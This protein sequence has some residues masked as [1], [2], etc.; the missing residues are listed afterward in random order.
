MVVSWDFGDGSPLLNTGILNPVTYT[1]SPPQK[2]YIVTVV[3][4]DTLTNQID[5][6]KKRVI[7][8]DEKANFT[9]DKTDICTNGLV[10]FYPF[11]NDS[12]KI[13]TYTWDF[14]DSTGR[15]IIDNLANFNNYGLWLKGN[16]SH[17]Y[18]DTGLY[19][20]KFIIEDKLGC[21][22]SIYY[23]LPISVRGPLVNFIPDIQL[24]CLVPLKVIFTDSSV[25]NG[26]ISII[27]WQWTFGN[28]SP[29]LNSTLDTAVSNLYTVNTY[30][31]NLK[32]TDSIGCFS[33][34]TKQIV[35]PLIT[36]G[37]QA[38]FTATPVKS[39]TSP[40]NVVFTDT[41]IQSGSVPIVKWDWNFGNG[42]T[43]ITDTD[44]AIN[45]IYNGTYYYNFYTVSLTITDSFGCISSVSKPN[46]IKIYQPKADFFSY[47]TLKCGAFNVF[48][49]NY[50]QVYNGN[51]TWYY[52][53]AASSTGYYGSH[54]YA[55]EGNYNIKMVVQ[56]ENGCSDSI[57][58]T[59]YIKLV[60]PQANFR[61][62]DT[63]RCA[64][65]AIAFSDSSTY[66]SSWV[67]DFG[68]GGTGST[69]QYP[70][71]HIYALPGFY[72]VTLR[73]KGLNN[74]EDSISK[75]IRV[76]GPIATLTANTGNGCKP[77]STAMN[78]RGSFI[79]TYAWDYGDGTP[80]LPN[81]TDSN[82]AHTYIN[83]GRYLPNVI[84][85][86]PEGCPFT[87]KASD[88]VFVDSVKAKFSFGPNK[89]CDSGYV[90]FTDQSIVPFFSSIRYKWYFGDGKIDTTATPSSHLYN[91][92]GVY[93]VKL[94]VTS[95]YGCVDSF[96]VANAINIYASP[97]ATINGINTVCLQPLTKLQYSSTVTSADAITK[98]KWSIDADSVAN[99]P[100]LNYN[101]RVP[102]NHVITFFIQTVNG[103]TFTITKNILIDSI[104][105]N[106][107]INPVRFC[108]SG[109]ASFNNLTTNFGAINFYNWR[110]GDG[111]TSTTQNPSNNYL[112]PN[113]YTVRLIAATVN[114]CRDTTTFV[115]T[116]RVFNLPSATI[117]GNAIVCL[118]PSTRLQY[119]SNITSVD[120]IAKYKW[121]IDADSVANTPDLNY[122]YRT[123]GNHLITFFIQTVN[124]CIFSI[125]KNILI[126]SIVTDFSISQVRFCTFGSPNFNNLTTSYGAINF[127]NWSFGDGNTSAL[128]NPSNNYLLPNNYTVQLIAETINGCRDTTVFTDT[129]HIYNL[130]HAAIIGDSIHCTPGIYQYLSSINSVD[131][132]VKYQWF[133]DNVQRSSNASLNY[134]FIAGNHIVSLKVTTVNGCTDSVATNIIV[135]SVKAL[136]SISQNKFCADTA[137]VLFT[138]NTNHLF[139]IATYQWSFGDNSNA[140]LQS[141][142]HN[143]QQ[144]GIYDVKLIV[145]TEHGCTDTL[146]KP[147]AIE[148]YRNPVATFTG[149]SIHCTPGN[150]RYISGSTANDPIAQYQWKVNGNIAG[151]ADTLDHNFIPAGLYD[152]MLKVTTDKGCVDDTTRRIIIDSVGAKFS[153]ENPKICGDTGTVRFN[154]LSASRFSNMNYRWNFGDAQTSTDINLTHFYTVA[155]HYLAT[156]KATTVNGCSSTYQSTDTVIIYT[157]T[158]AAIVG[159]NEKCMQN[160]LVYQANIVTQDAITTY[161]WKLNN[162]TISNADTML[163]NFVNA[164]NYTVQLN[165][166]TGYGC[167]VTVSKPVV[168]HPLP[169]PA[170]A[171]D[172]TICRG[173]FVQLRSFDGVI[174]QWAASASLQNINSATPRAIPVVTTN[175][176]VAVTNQFGCVQNDTVTVVVDEPVN[177]TVSVNDSLCIGERRQLKATST[178]NNYLW[179]PSGTLSN[180]AAANPYASPTVTTPYQVIAFSNNVCNSD[181][182]Y[183]T[184]FVGNKP[185]VNAGADRN[186]A[187]GTPIQ[188]FAQAVGND[189]NRYLWEPSTGLDCVSCPNP[190]L[191][192]DDNIT[193]RVTVETIFG[194]TATDEMRI[195]VFCGKGQLY[196][197]NAFSPNGD[198]L[199]DIFYVKGFGLAKIKKMMIFNRLGQKVFE[200]QDV[201]VNDKSQGWNGETQG[202]PPTTTAAYVYILE[203]VCKDGQEFSYKGMLML[204]R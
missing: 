47:D 197:P 38:G 82:V 107:S 110:F 21:S 190:K 1:F 155:G 108:G 188:L 58:R 80:V 55:A 73:V 30:N 156:L 158:T 139:N 94:V 159:V 25:Q 8:I 135:D 90:N 153:I 182:G 91:V 89:F 59:S 116:I 204:V 183:V 41:S 115:D 65:T 92:P 144:A 132:I 128:Q 11:G 111:N 136:F 126:D 50:A 176:S 194:C 140:S 16:T 32:V 180:P 161:T 35:V 191:M 170:A 192:A 96:T 142:V 178:V 57:T 163:Y 113:N 23:P 72:K 76:R 177:L 40:Q 167:D 181:T 36:S 46:Y 184:I 56:D 13:K 63:T 48:L 29:V 131:N 186:V 18:I 201:P 54:T 162:N 42:T 78:V 86:S 101:Y 105:T 33:S 164:G 62:G 150:F 127:Y 24:S 130:P 87:L 160:V 133:V 27:N 81:I 145:T 93:T 109:M 45:K 199:N 166:R 37:P 125:T 124:G 67:W 2:A 106:F 66:S 202:Q 61:I 154:N 26:I 74:C 123:P 14:G 187:N 53:D 103:C 52:G 9:P 88:T 84:L 148:I 157:T 95:K 68:D 100:N 117:N 28:G 152:V 141:P 75:I 12:S 20:V 31:V 185:T 179:S 44:T 112:L 173:G 189:I 171:P 169:V 119:T 4:L 121:S 99:T 49:Y 122:N 114:G 143:Y 22:D 137:R 104:V 98:Y 174:Y 10:N 6:G 60:H 165:V 64:P 7:I 70:S 134:N 195:V 51:Y 193:Y 168:I 146:L 149:D 196:I 43:L 15:F 138:D 34:I 118:V 203:V 175:Y 97:L 172:T 69:D 19:Y 200:K 151:T 198:G 83:A 147:R 5:T 120:A 39:C 17:T 129:I 3:R 85:T 79:K 102:G 71:P 77:Y